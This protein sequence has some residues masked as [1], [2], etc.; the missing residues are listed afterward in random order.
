MIIIAA[1]ADARL[2]A[3]AEGNISR[4]TACGRSDA[5]PTALI[6]WPVGVVVA[7]QRWLDERKACVIGSSSAVAK[8]SRNKR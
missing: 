3:A 6:G 7:C 8:Y 2:M 4:D 5:D 1:A